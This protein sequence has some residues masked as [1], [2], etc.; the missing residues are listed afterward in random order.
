MK[1][2]CLLLIALMLFFILCLGI[3]ACSS[4]VKYNLQ[5]WVDDEIYA[6]TTFS[7]SNIENMPDDPIKQYYVFDGWY[8]DK[9]TWRKP[10]TI[11][12]LLDSPISKDNTFPVYAKFTKYSCDLDNKQH[13]YETIENEQPTCTSYGHILKRCSVCGNEI[14]QPLSP[15]QHSYTRVITTQ[16]TCEIAGVRTYTCQRENCNHLYVY[17]FKA[18]G[19]SYTNSITTQ[20]T[21]E[22]A[23]V[24]T[25]TCQRENCNHTYTESIKATG[26]LYTKWDI[27]TLPSCDDNGEEVSVCEHGCGVVG[28]R[29]IT[30]LGHSL[31]ETKHCTRNGCNYFEYFTFNVSMFTPCDAALKLQ[32]SAE[33]GEKFSVKYPPVEIDG[34]T[35]KG[36]YTDSGELFADNTGKSV[37]IYDCKDTDKI[38]NASLFAVYT[39]TI[40]SAEQLKNLQSDSDLIGIYSHEIKSKCL[41]FELRNNIDIS[42]AEWKPIGSQDKPFCSMF[43]GKNYTISG[44][45]IS[46][47]LPYAG[48]FGYTKGV[49]FKNINLTNVN[50]NIPTVTSN[51]KVGAL[52]AYD[53]DYY[54]TSKEYKDIWKGV[55]RS[56]YHNINTNNGNIT[57]ANHS[58]SYIS[59]AG[60]MI[61]H[62]NG[63]ATSNNIINNISINK[64]TY[65]GGIIGYGLYNAMGC[66][67]NGTITSSKYAGGICGYTSY[68]NVTITQCKNNGNI[69]SVIQAG[70]LVGHS[71]GTNI[72]YSANTGNITLTGNSDLSYGA[73]GL[74]GLAS[75][76]TVTDSYN[77]GSITSNQNAGGLLGSTSINSLP[78][79]L[80]ATHCYNSGTIKGDGFSGGI[81]GYCHTASIIESI[82][83]GSGKSTLAQVGTT[84]NFDTSYYNN[85][86]LNNQ[87]IQTNARYIKDFYVNTLF[88]KE[89]DAE[90]QSGYWKFTDNNYPTLWWEE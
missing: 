18:L 72:T 2:K 47:Q 75:S 56:S 66:I 19:H 57:I 6:E 28:S 21:C 8:L 61:G 74:I 29:P 10:L 69:E 22:T 35:L 40:S 55:I 67:N 58:E 36:I 3:S 87:G 12:A 16:P 1:R 38:H 53:D 14:R 33:H 89:Y 65:S 73:G 34:L 85:S 62:S 24:R 78:A 68:A 77:T 70:G 60:G 90:A 82:N 86:S 42:G 88:W 9:N 80:T 45:T 30:A 79:K 27:K 64:A 31:D 13:N 46:T 81:A 71:G 15:L 43:D 41:E 23:G 54:F 84:G 37:S 11:Q 17:L 4:P 59:Y 48:L 7:N 32:I 25:Y 52:T 26:H 39:Y 63:A 76:L 44:L 51:I 49:T 50:I 83:H 5:F 20:P